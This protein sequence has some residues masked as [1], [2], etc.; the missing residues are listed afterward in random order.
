MAKLRF[1][2]LSVQPTGWWRA[3]TAC[4]RYL[5]IVVLLIHGLVLNFDKAVG[6]VWQCL[7]RQTWAS[8][9]MLEA[10]VA[11]FSFLAWIMWFRILDSLPYFQRFRFIQREGGPVPSELLEALSNINSPTSRQQTTLHIWASLPIYLLAIALLHCIKEPKALTLEAPSFLRVLIELAAGIWM[12]DFVYYWIHLLMHR[13]PRFPHGHGM[14][15]ELSSLGSDATKTEFVEAAS[16]V[17][18]TL[19][20]GGLQVVVNICVQNLPLLGCPKH[21]MSRLLHNILVTYM[22]T[23]A[24]A[25]LDLPWC[26]HRVFPEVFGGSLRHE[27]HHHLHRCYYH[28]FFKYLDDFFGYGAPLGTIVL[29]EEK[30][31]KL[32]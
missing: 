13:F 31:E 2:L 28:Q 8:S 19:I 22:L 15:H 20:D 27:I 24:H 18:H 17:N 21:K 16:V 5:P 3:V 26:C 30:Q 29:A 14:H 25:G 11:A 10:N 4:L 9:A 32:Q 7:A 6:S 23:E 1:Q 12:Y